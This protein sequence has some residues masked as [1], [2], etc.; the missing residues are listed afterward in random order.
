[1]KIHNDMYKC[2]DTKSYVNQKE[3]FAYFVVEIENGKR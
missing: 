3:N 1:M 2:N